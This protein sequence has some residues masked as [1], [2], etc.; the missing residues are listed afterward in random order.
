IITDKSGNEIHLDTTGSNINITA[1]ETININAKNINI[2]ASEN[3]TSTAGLNITEGAGVNHMSTAGGM[4]MQNAVLDYS[5]MAA[6]IL[7]V[8]KGDISSESTNVK[9][10][11][12]KDIEVISA[13]GTIHHNAQKE[14]KNNSGEKGANY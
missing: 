3:I 2:S 7:K 10:N 6:N 14:V 4:M 12:S 5:L 13:E 9:R 11:A 8:A 1:P